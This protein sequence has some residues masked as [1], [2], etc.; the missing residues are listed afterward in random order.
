MPQGSPDRR[1]VLQ[2][3]G[4]LAASAALP[5]TT[6]A[7]LPVHSFVAI[8]D[9]GRDG[10]DRQKQVA[11]A[12]AA[13]AADVDSRFVLSV[14]D[15]FYP[16]GVS[17]ARDPQWRTSFEEIYPQAALHTPWYVALGN[18]DH[19]GDPDAQIAYSQQSRRWRMP[20]RYY[21]A[22]SEQTAMPGL[23]L[24]VLDT[25][26]MLPMHGEL[27]AQTIRGRF[28]WGRRDDQLAWLDAALGRSRAPWKVVVGHHPIYTGGRHGEPP[29]LIAD[30]A[31]I[32]EKHS[33][34]AYVAGH[35]HVLQHVRR[36]PVD[37]IVT[38]SGA[39]AGPVRTVKGTRFK[40]SREGFAVFSVQPETMTL[41]FRDF[42]GRSLYRAALPRVRA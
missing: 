17:S 9:W 33:V 8:G 24:F 25:A 26:P 15:N 20:A 30:L 39:S 34:Q 14:G 18:H 23:D 38:G 12:M 28:S 11:A 36:G 10:A 6:Q 31:P 19:R 42:A 3:L 35:D 27:L 1:I 37:Y 2:G 13:A 32:L 7:K 29:E 5:Q 4:G 40:A 22:T 16:A 21:V 41:E